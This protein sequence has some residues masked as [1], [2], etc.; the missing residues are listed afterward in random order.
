[1]DRTAGSCRMQTLRTVCNRVFLAGI[2]KCSCSIWYLGCQNL[3]RAFAPGGRLLTCAR[4]GGGVAVY[5]DART[6]GPIPA[7]CRPLGWG[8]GALALPLPVPWQLWQR[9]RTAFFLMQDLGALSPTAG[10]RGAPV[11]FRAGRG[12]S[13]NPAPPTRPPPGVSLHDWLHCRTGS[14]SL[15]QN[16]VPCALGKDYL[17]QL[18][19]SNFWSI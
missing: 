4:G 11:G 8:Q 15:H 13:Q 14:T 16:P 18:L 7:Q 10:L 3:P 5:G 2:V 9:T 19:G 17:Y 1:M 12:C 6:G